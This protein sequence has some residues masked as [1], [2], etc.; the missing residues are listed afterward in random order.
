MRNRITMAIALLSLM[1][2][3]VPSMASGRTL[4]TRLAAGNEVGQ[5]GDPGT[6]GR[7]HMILN[8][9]DAEVC[10]RIDVRGESTPILAAHIHAGAADV[11]GPVVVDLQ[12][13]ETN[14]Q[15]CVGAD[16]TILEAIHAN[17]SDYYVNVHNETA[18][19]GAARGQL[20]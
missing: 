19:A 3:A 17:P 20:G 12:W 16:A 18:P 9:G 15:G 1:T 13:A 14:G 4:S 5:P 2:L 10:F 8:Q 6:R 11:N 7:V